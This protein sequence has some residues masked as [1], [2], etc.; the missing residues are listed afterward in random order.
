MPQQTDQ[1]FVQDIYYPSNLGPPQKFMFLLFRYLNSPCPYFPRYHKKPEK[2]QLGQSFVGAIEVRIWKETTSCHQWSQVCTCSNGVKN[3]GDSI[4]VV[5]EV[6][7]W[8]FELD[9]SESECLDLSR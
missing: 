6:F 3:L 4:I 7:K 9:S 2:R 5:H 1:Y 8:M